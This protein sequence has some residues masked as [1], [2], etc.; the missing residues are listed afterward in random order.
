MPV[1]TSQDSTITFD[2]ITFKATKCSVSFGGGSSS[3]S[4]N[5]IDVSHLGLADGA[6][7]EYQNAPLAEV[8][9]A[10]GTGVVATITVDFL[11]LQKPELN[12]T[13]AIDLGQKL[14]IKGTARCT[15][16]QLDAT[17]NDV[18]RGTAKFDLMTLS[19]TY[20]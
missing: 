8:A 15:E 2:A 9:S 16:Y 6:N 20:P 17:V 4:D 19:A 12:V 13:K 1:T 3:S 7:K 5:T 11:D 14:A 10:G 18:I